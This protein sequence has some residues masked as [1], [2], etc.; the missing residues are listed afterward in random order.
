[1]SEP[2]ETG[3]LCREN[4]PVR[5]SVL[6]EAS[7]D[8]A[9]AAARLPNEERFR[10]IN[11]LDDHR[12]ELPDD[13]SALGQELQKIDFK[14]NLILDMLGP[15]VSAG[16]QPP[17]TLALELAPQHLSLGGEQA[18]ID[19]VFV[20]DWLQ[21]ELFLHPRYPFPVV[22]FGR[23]SRLDGGVEIDLLP[24]SEAVREQYEKYLFRC[25]RRQI[26]RARKR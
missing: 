3:L 13:S 15:L 14:L 26:A 20:G 6:G 12:S 5:W 2:V 9:Q 24:L 18:D 1:M 7:L 11:S 19:G 21:V 25:H 22:L 17:V 16:S 23:V 10:I 8:A 4:L